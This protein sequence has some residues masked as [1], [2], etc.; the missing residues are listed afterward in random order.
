M[1]SGDAIRTRRD[2]VEAPKCILL[3]RGFS[4]HHNIL[5]NLILTMTWRPLGRTIPNQ[6]TNP[7][8]RPTRRWVFHCFEGTD[9]LHFRH[10]PDPA[11]ALV[12]RP[13]PLHHQ[14]LP[15]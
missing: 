5:S 14:V 3:G 4:L 15:R 11:V 12:L 9:L 7:T 13:E 1:A 10:R 2:L 6:V 8:D